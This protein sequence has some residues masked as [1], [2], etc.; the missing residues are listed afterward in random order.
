MLIHVDVAV[1]NTE[2]FSVDLEAQQWIPFLCLST[3]QNCSVLPWKHNNG[4]QL[5]CY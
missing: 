2:L 3:I 1:N 4:F 5:Y